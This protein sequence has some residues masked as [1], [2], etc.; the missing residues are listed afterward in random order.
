[1][2]NKENRGRNPL[3]NKNLEWNQYNINEVISNVIEGYDLPPTTVPWETFNSKS[4]KWVKSEK[5]VT[6]TEAMQVTKKTDYTHAQAVSYL[7]K[8]GYRIQRVVMPINMDAKSVGLDESIPKLETEKI[9]TNYVHEFVNQTIPDIWSET[10]KVNRCWLFCS[11]S[12]YDAIK[13]FVR[14][15]PHGK[16]KYAEAALVKWVAKSLQNIPQ[17]IKVATHN[18]SNP[19]KEIKKGGK[20]DEI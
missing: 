9:C 18:L 2:N 15:Y 6:N 17:K 10:D 16:C 8:E 3:L 5:K 20:M 19:K 14:T 7:E 13:E 1:M 11:Q 4:G 12:D